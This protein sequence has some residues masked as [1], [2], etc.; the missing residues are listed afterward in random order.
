MTDPNDV[1]VIEIVVLG[2]AVYAVSHGDGWVRV[3]SL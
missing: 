3:T 1:G 2:G